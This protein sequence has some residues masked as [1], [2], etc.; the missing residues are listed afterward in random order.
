ML[1]MAQKS[2]SLEKSFD[3]KFSLL[4]GYNLTQGKSA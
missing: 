4:E 1:K 3:S 2:H